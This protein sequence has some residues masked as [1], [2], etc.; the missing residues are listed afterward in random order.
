MSVHI[1]LPQDTRAKLIE[2]AL[3]HFAANGYAGSS[4]RAIQR[5]LDLNPASVHYYFGSK[6]ALYKAVV[7]TF[8]GEI[9]AERGRRL[10]VIPTDLERK[11]RLRRLIE[12]YVAPH[13][14]FAVSEVGH[15]YARLLARVSVETEGPLL[16]TFE[17]I[18]M[19]MRRRYLKALEALYPDVERA[20]IGRLLAMTVAMMTWAPLGRAYFLQTGVDYVQEGA[21]RWIA[22]IADYAVAAYEALPSALRPKDAS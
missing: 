7:D 1:P 20:E 13:L 3:H 9:T 4:L 11:V 22:A 19:P 12:A 15:A 14:E 8:I 18:A 10:E 17:A 16:E 6:E 21:P 5:D 2:T